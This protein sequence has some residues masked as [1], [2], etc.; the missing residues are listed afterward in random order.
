M[1]GEYAARHARKVNEVCRAIALPLVYYVLSH[2]SCEFMK[3]PDGQ[4]HRG[5][6]TKLSWELKRV[7]T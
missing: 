7:Y 3:R 5:Y 1:P 6:I 2:H 4:L